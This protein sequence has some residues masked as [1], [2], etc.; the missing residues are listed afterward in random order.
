MSL[1]AWLVV[2]GLTDGTVQ[3]GGSRTQC[4]AIPHNTSDTVVVACHNREVSTG[5]QGP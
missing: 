3:D 4:R 5:V 1:T 2:I